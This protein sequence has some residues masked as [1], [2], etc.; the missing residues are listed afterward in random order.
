VATHDTTFQL[1]FTSGKLCLERQ[2]SFLCKILGSGVCFAFVVSFEAEACED[3]GCVG[4]Q[5]VF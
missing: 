2:Y 5:V 1:D 4:E 3:G